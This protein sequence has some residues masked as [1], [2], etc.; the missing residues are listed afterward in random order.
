MI[1]LQSV[2]LFNNIDV[3]D[4]QNAFYWPWTHR[5]V[6]VYTVGQVILLTKQLIHMFK[7][8]RK[9]EVLLMFVLF[10]NSYLWL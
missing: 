8:V 9:T 5:H 4:P 7:S 1:G 2:G 3:I 6:S 10:C